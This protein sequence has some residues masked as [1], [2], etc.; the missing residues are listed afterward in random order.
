V[1]WSDGGARFHYI[2][3][4]FTNAS[5][6]ASFVQPTM[7]VGSSDGGL[8]ILWPGWAAP[9]KLESTTDLTPPVLWSELGV[10]IIP[11][12]SMLGVHLPMTNTSQFYRLKLP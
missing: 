11:T 7:D 4:P 10:P 3:V 5:F 12:N 1:V 2:T 6:T 9:M 8:D